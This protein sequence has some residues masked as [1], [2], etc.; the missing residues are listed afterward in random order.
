MA[1]RMPPYVMRK[2]AA[3]GDSNRHDKSTPLMPAQT[4]VLPEADNDSWYP[5][6]G[7]FSCNF[8]TALGI[9]S[10]A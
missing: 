9:T 10:H 6:W 4:H 8:I 3:I 5:G 7:T 1:V 2:P